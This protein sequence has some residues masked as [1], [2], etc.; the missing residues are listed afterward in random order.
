MTSPKIKSWSLRKRFAVTSLATLLIILVAFIFGSGLYHLGRSNQLI[1]SQSLKTLI[2]ERLSTP[3]SLPPAYFKPSTC[4]FSDY[5]LTLLYDPSWLINQAPINLCDTFN[6]QLQ[7]MTIT[8]RTQVFNQ[9]RNQTI[10]DL[11]QS[12]LRV[13]TNSFN[14]P[15]YELTH[16]QGYNSNFQLNQAYWVI[17]IAPTQTLV[18]SLSGGAPDIYPLIA[19]FIN[20]L[21]VLP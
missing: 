1:Q 5:P 3:E 17:A 18:I 15:L 10:H 13:E 12:L 20:S 11:S 8:L 2:T 19:G 6:L 16:I 9:D 7:A 4:Q 14:H 21:E